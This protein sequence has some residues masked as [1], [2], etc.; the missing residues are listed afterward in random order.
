MDLDDCTE[1]L[2]TK[3]DQLNAYR[4]KVQSLRQQINKFTKDRLEITDTMQQRIAYQDKHSTLTK[5]R[6]Q[7]RHDLDDLRRQTQPL[8]RALDECRSKERKVE[9]ERESASQEFHNQL[10]KLEMYNRNISELNEW[11]R[12]F[13]HSGK[14]DQFDECDRKIRGVES[15]IVEFSRQRAT[16]VDENGEQ[17]RA[18]A[19]SKV[20]FRDMEDSLKVKEKEQHIRDLSAKIARQTDEFERLGGLD[21][22][23][24]D[25]DELVAR[26]ARLIQQLHQIE[27]RMK[28]SE[29]FLAEK[30]EQSNSS[31][32]KD[33]DANYTKKLIQQVTTETAANDLVKYYKALDGAV[34]QYHSSKMEEINSKLR[35]LWQKIYK[36]NDIDFIAIR[37]DTEIADKRRAYNY[38]VV[39][40]SGG[41][42]LDM[43]G[44]CSAGQKVL[45]C[46]LIRIA[47]AEVFSASC[48]VLALDEPTTNL[49]EANIRGLAEAM[50]EIIEEK[51]QQKNFQLILITHD[52]NFL[53]L[54][55]RGYGG[56]RLDTHFRI[57]K[58]D[59]GYT[60][61]LEKKNTELME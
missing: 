27:G 15:D 44:R 56:D 42:E 29:Q 19:R 4:E 10:R 33:A 47:L 45:A 17:E 58:D 39:M 34:I 32:Y 22:A 51:S 20:K 53:R 49:D 37:S 60:Q 28:L 2:E 23:G 54:L 12:K 41:T 52:E 61:I 48:G 18:L 9:A 57:T 1:A 11:I 59:S 31:G 40:H 55:L 25:Y 8:K 6:D 7:C 35:E 38:R 3:Q 13:Q 16:L 46:I 43:R 14:K 26:H 50:V 5:Q 21:M 36:N 30:R 24:G